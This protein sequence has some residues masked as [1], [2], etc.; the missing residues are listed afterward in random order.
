M[1][2]ALKF[3]VNGRKARAA[4]LE[5]AGLTGLKLI[6]KRA[7]TQ[8]AVNHFRQKS[9][10]YRYQEKDVENHRQGL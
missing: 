4:I 5:E 3:R 2:E 7:E 10:R 6:G 8:K 9:R 1:I